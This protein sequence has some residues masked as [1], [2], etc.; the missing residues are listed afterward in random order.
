MRVLDGAGGFFPALGVLSAGGF[1]YDGHGFSDGEEEERVNPHGVWLLPAA[2]LFADARGRSSEDDDTDDGPGVA[3]S[4]S[5]SEKKTVLQNNDWIRVPVAL[6]GSLR[7]RVQTADQERQTDNDVAKDSKKSKGGGFLSSLFGGGAK[8]KSG[9]GAPATTQ[10]QL[11][12]LPLDLVGHANATAAF[13]AKNNALQVMFIHGGRYNNSGSMAPT[14]SLITVSLTEGRALADEI[15]TAGMAPAA[16][17]SHTM[18]A[19]PREDGGVSLYLFGGYV[20]GQM[21]G[22]SDLWQ[23]DLVPESVEGEDNSLT[24]RELSLSDEADDNDATISACGVRS[25]QFLTPSHGTRSAP[26]ARYDHTCVYHAGTNSLYVFGGISDT[27]Y[28]GDLLRFDLA[29]HVWEQLSPSVA[30]GGDTHPPPRARHTACIVND[31]WMA[32][33]GGFAEAGRC[34]NDVWLYS[35]NRNRW[36]RVC[37]PEADSDSAALVDWPASRRDHCA[38]TISDGDGAE[39]MI[40][41]GGKSG[42][43]PLDDVGVLP[44]D[45]LIP[46]RD[47]R[48]LFSRGFGTGDLVSFGCSRHGQLG[49]PHN[50]EDSHNSDEAQCSRIPQRVSGVAKLRTS[51]F[52]CGGGHSAS[53]ANPL[54]GRHTTDRTTEMFVWGDARSNSAAPVPRPITFFKGRSVVKISCGALHTAV[55]CTSTADPTKHEV[56]VFG[57][58]VGP[59]VQEAVARTQPRLIEALG[60][61][62][63]TDIASTSLDVV[64]VTQDGAV[65]SYAVSSQSQVKLISTPSDGSGGMRKMPAFSRVACGGAH[66]L[67][68]S[69]SGALYTF[70]D[71]CGYGQLG[72]GEDTS[73]AP[74]PTVVPLPDGCS[75]I[76]EIS[77]GPDHS[78]CLDS[79]GHAFAWGRNNRLQCG[80]SSDGKSVFDPTLIPGLSEE[81]L[82]S[83]SAGGGL[84]DA[85]TLAVS[86]SNDLYAWGSNNFGQCAAPV[87]EVACLPRLVSELRGAVLRAESGWQH[88]L[89][90]IRESFLLPGEH[91]VDDA[92]NPADDFPLGDFE[93]ISN[94][95]VTS[96]LKQLSQHDVCAM[97]QVC[98]SMRQLADRDE[99]WEAI[100]SYDRMRYIH[101]G[102]EVEYPS[103]K[104]FCRERW[105]QDH[106]SVRRR[107][108]KEE[109]ERAEGQKS[110]LRRGFQNVLKA[111][112]LRFGKKEIRVL[113]VGLDAAGKT[114][115]LYKLKLGEVVTTIPTIGFNVETVEYK[116]ASITVW[117]VCAQWATIACS[118]SYLSPLANCWVFSFSPQRLAVPTKSAPCGAITTKTRRP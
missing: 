19:V 88:N 20:G 58:T 85:H 30:D 54:A 100:T 55:V 47:G 86:E 10:V 12:L 59:S 105:L 44:S 84:G 63:I 9:D 117:D 5:S 91:A 16:R 70:G 112:V 109:A 77:A 118:S 43:K 56:W 107:L 75:E 7:A 57:D 80:F 73:S 81:V 18:C 89:V 21:R 71:R 13:P 93:F 108:E 39:R 45:A 95:I 15:W 48:V 61:H 103:Y 87:E 83:V 14:E 110:I 114:T 82:I 25:W 22:M 99:V 68:L 92:S 40:V 17:Q 23:L 28:F 76:V 50:M 116:R 37:E 36:T 94:D 98:S 2:A 60:Q 90:L 101:A 64:V 29:T 3:P 113:M 104:S 53:L 42:P 67:L 51:K 102:A 66:S 96:I 26:P 33:F 46:S 1:D 115:I 38:V 11:Q 34:P 49:T 79:N 24:R 41:F 72:L 31:H 6:T 8:G 65:Y 69:E 106:P 4:P 32:V 52:S 27:T 97:C 111:G 35:F 62:C 78:I 74:H